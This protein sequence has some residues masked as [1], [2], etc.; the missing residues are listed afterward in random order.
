MSTS[1]SPAVSPLLTVNEAG[2]EEGGEEIASVTEIVAVEGV[3]EIVTGI[4]T[5]IGIGIGIEIGI[6]TE[7]E[8]ADEGVE[9]R[10]E[11]IGS[12]EDAAEMMTMT[13]K[14]ARAAAVAVMTMMKTVIDAGDAIEIYLRQQN[15]MKG[16]ASLL[17]HMIMTKFA[18]TQCWPRLCSCCCAGI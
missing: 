8:I 2:E 12:Q 9:M 7:I 17:H 6:G 1:V 13:T 10:I 5:G 11:E 18:F 3:I 15:E 14:V 4:V 16:V